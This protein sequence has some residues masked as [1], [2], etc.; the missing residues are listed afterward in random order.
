MNT[1]PTRIA[2]LL[3]G[4]TMLAGAGCSGDGDRDRDRDASAST[5]PTP[6]STPQSVSAEPRHPAAVSQATDLTWR[7]L[8]SPTGGETVQAASV[9]YVVSTTPDGRSAV[10]RDDQGG[11]V[12]TY[13]APQDSVISQ[14][15]LE[16]P[17][18]AIVTAD[19]TEERDEEV[20][21]LDLRN[22]AER[23]LS[24]DGAQPW[25]GSWS[26]GSALTYGTRGPGGKYCLAAA[27]LKDLV[28]EV[29]ECVPPRNGIHQPRQSPYGLGYVTFTDTRPMSC[30]TARVRSLGAKSGSGA[31]E[32]PDGPAECKVWESVPLQDGG[33]A[34]SEVPKAR[35]IELADIFVREEGTA[36]FLAQGATGSLKWCGSSL[37]FVQ[38]VEG[39]LLRWTPGEGLEEVFSDPQHHEVAVLSEPVCSGD[40]VAVTVL[41]GEPGQPN[42]ETVH[43]AAIS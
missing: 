31:A 33:A 35:Q 15:F 29:V 13:A 3:V 11:A 8:A 9:E 2:H 16:P 4:V 21:V 5:P 24:Q 12:L 26:F 28:G 32:D 18:L 10:V 40:A 36:A 43:V 38:Q 20:A 7:E 34:W 42:E 17:W 23:A 22:G 27:G 1:R 37:W 30:G 39:R 14:V 6:S 25:K 41:S 19:P